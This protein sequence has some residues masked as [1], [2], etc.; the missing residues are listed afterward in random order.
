M[1]SF[2]DGRRN[3]R[4]KAGG[5]ALRRRATP[6][7]VGAIARTTVEDLDLVAEINRL[8]D[9]D[10]AV[11]ALDHDS[12]AHHRRYDGTT[13]ARR[14]SVTSRCVE[15]VNWALVR[16]RDIQRVSGFI[17]IHDRRKSTRGGR[18]ATS[19]IRI[20]G[21][22]DLLGSLTATRRVGC[23]TAAD[24]NDGNRVTV[25]AGK[26]GEKSPMREVKNQVGGIRSGIDRSD[27]SAL[28]CVFPI[29]FCPVNDR[30]GVVELIRDIGR[31]CRLV[32]HDMNRPGA[33]RYQRC[34]PWQLRWLHCHRRHRKPCGRNHQDSA[35]ASSNS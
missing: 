31:V 34:D 19:P 5:E 21:K 27:R 16:V 1:G 30:D 14:T 18:G 32:D 9:K 11:G 15:Y 12:I 20:A 17:E 4:E 24:V 35:D 7:L 13:T 28:R 2:I 25:S 6:G 23:V 8:D 3:I 26:S 22:D 33:R 10:A 29:A